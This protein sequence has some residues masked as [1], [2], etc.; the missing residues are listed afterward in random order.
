ML[1]SATFLTVKSLDD[2]NDCAV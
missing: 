2:E 1:Y